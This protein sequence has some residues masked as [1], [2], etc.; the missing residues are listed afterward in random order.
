MFELLI[1]LLIKASLTVL[2]TI[3]SYVIFSLRG[4]FPRI[5]TE[6]IRFTYSYYQINTDI[7]AFLLSFTL[8][9]ESRLI[10]FP[11]VTKIFQFTSFITE[12]L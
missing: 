9:V 5:Q 6:Y 10:S 4:R 2:C 3:A 7:Q 11:E 8:I 12:F 1:K